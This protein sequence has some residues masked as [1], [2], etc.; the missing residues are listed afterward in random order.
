LRPNSVIQERNIGS[1]HITHCSQAAQIVIFP[2]LAHHSIVV[3]TCANL[4]P[5]SQ[6]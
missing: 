5:C 3:P 4:C 6:A 2:S 1:S